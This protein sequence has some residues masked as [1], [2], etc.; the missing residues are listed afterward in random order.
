M[1][2]DLLNKWFCEADLEHPPL[3]RPSKR[4]RLDNPDTDA[5][6]QLPEP[7]ISR[8]ARSIECPVITTPASPSPYKPFQEGYWN[9]LELPVA[10][11]LWLNRFRDT[12]FPPEQEA[13]GPY[14]R[15]SIASP[16]VRRSQ[17]DSHLLD[18]RRHIQSEFSQMEDTSMP[19]PSPAATSQYRNSIPALYDRGRTPSRSG[20]SEVTG[21]SSQ[22]GRIDA[23]NTNYRSKVLKRNGINIL[24]ATAPLSAELAAEAHNTR[25]RRDSPGLSDQLAAEICGQILMRGDDEE[26]SVEGLLPEK[27]ILPRDRRDDPRSH[28]HLRYIRRMPYSKAFPLPKA[29]KPN[30]FAEEAQSNTQSIVIPS[31]DIAYGYTLEGF[32]SNQRFALGCTIRGVD[33]DRLSMPAKDL[34]WPF[35]V[36]E[37][38]ALPT[39]GNIYWATNQ[40]AGGGAVSVKATQTL[41]ALASQFCEGFSDPMEAVAYSAAI[42][43]ELAIMYMHW[44]DDG[45][46]YMER[47][48]IYLL[49]RPA[50]L[51]QFRKQV[52]NILDWAFST[53]LDMIKSALDV[54][55]TSGHKGVKR[56]ISPPAS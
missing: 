30:D 45:Q 23:T 36:V 40:C 8:R 1:Q 26:S 27:G 3:E 16:T 47:I 17:S 49:S 20:R 34:F 32:N 28:Q 19:P 46:Y 54:V 2:E 39:G 14:S 31:P 48:N 33:L 38:K 5:P 44:F 37:F 18:T 10:R 15:N 13:L 11:V 35:L 50:E 29:I 12:V 51:I 55:S 43:G 25:R 53:R 41:F 6:N 7:S 52:R 24:N 4:R 9:S 21:G 42:D 56:P 22:T